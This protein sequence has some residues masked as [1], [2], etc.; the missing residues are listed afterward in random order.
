MKLVKCMTVA[1][2]DSGGGAGIQGDLKTFAAL[3]AYGMSVITALTAQNTKEVRAIHAVPPDFVAE[4]FRAIM[5]DIGCDS[6]KTG[7]LATEEII[8][9]VADQLESNP[10]IPIVVDP[11]MV[12]TTG[13]RLLEVTA[14]KAMVFRLLPLATV[15]TPNAPEAEILA[16]CRI[17]SVDDAVRAAEQIARLGPG[18]VLVKGG[19]A[20]IEPDNVID[21]LYHAGTPFVLRS[22]RVPTRHTHGS[23]CCLAS[24]ICVGLGQGLDVRAAVDLGRDFVRRAIKNA[25]AIGAGNSPVNHLHGFKENLTG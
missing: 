6:I 24:A 1:G 4:Q 18:T 13:A 17:S 10:R 7:M 12:S 23:G 2:S 20:D 5:D 15:V 11:V 8:E 22:R 19:D 14:V 9:V 25:V 16:G 21:V 3:G